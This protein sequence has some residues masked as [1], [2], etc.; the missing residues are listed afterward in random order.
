MPT[1]TRVPG[2]TCV[3][4]PTPGCLG[5]RMYDGC[6]VVGGAHARTRDVCY[7]TSSPCPACRE[8]RAGQVGGGGQ[9]SGSRMEGGRGCVGGAQSSVCC[10]DVVVNARVCWTRGLG[11][12][13]L[14]WAVGAAVP[15]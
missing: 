5:V 3:C 9:G 8:S 1:R 12:A 4:L 15:T 7:S 14:G 11:W 13:R 6:M 10:S 2:G